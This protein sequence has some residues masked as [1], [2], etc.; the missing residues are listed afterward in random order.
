MGNLSNEQKLYDE[1]LA[2]VQSVV[3]SIASLELLQTSYQS[4]RLSPGR[5]TQQDTK[6]AELRKV[7]I[8]VYNNLVMEYGKIL[9]RIKK[10]ERMGASIPSEERTVDEHLEAAANAMYVKT[11]Y[12][13]LTGVYNKKYMLSTLEDFL[14]NAKDPDDA[15]SI[16]A[17]DIDFLGELNKVNGLN[18]GDNC[19][20]RIAATIKD[21]LFHGKDIVARIDGG[22]FIVLLPNTKKA[23]AR[24]ISDRIL[25]Q[26]SKLQIPHPSS[27]VSGNITVSIG[28]VTGT[29][30]KTRWGVND[31]LTCADEALSI[32]KSQ[33]RNRYVYQ[34]L[35]I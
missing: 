20:R 24:T 18:I 19:I 31:F 14:A 29:K 5:Q 15:L 30:G 22:K 28:V 25:A 12:D 32:A 27:S 3:D 17:I 23:N 1:S 13:K 21:S 2:Y 33:G 9:N 34:G 7:D 8:D 4:F 11:D 16:A 10:M 26:V 35:K 6:I